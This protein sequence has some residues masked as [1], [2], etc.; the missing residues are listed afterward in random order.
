[1]EPI[2]TLIASA[3]AMGAAAGLKPTVEQ[4]IKDAYSGLKHLIKS[5]YGNNEDVMDAVDYVTKKPEAERRREM[6]QEVLTEAG[7]EEDPETMTAAK[8]VHDAVQRN[9]PSIAESIGMDIGLLKAAALEVE[10]VLA[11]QGGTAVRI[12]KAEIEG[13]AIFSGIGGGTSGKK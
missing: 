2:T 12:N 9:D 13:P 7:A 1:M 8:A 11:G 3:I 4:A 5:R 10:N 6:L